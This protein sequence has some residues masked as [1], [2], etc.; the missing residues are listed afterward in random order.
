MN[1]TREIF[2]EN[3]T[4]IFQNFLINN[5]LKRLEDN[6]ITNFFES[7]INGNYEDSLK[8]LKIFAKNDSFSSYI[9]ELPFK[10]LFRKIDFLNYNIDSI[11]KKFHLNLKY[12][13]L[14]VREND[15]KNINNNNINNLNILKILNNLNFLIKEEDN[16]IFNFR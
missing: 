6:N 10:I 14:I 11:I 15:Y 1:L 2:R 4:D 13:N 9:N 12:E 16:K 7:I 8:I 3:S 5:L